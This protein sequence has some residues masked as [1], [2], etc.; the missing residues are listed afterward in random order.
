MLQGP[1][2]KNWKI[3]YYKGLGTS[4]NKE[5]KE[6]FENLQSHKI[7]FVFENEEDTKAMELSFSKK[8]V[9]ERKDWLANYNPD[10]YIDHN[11]HAITYKEF[12]NKELIHFS[13]SDNVRSIPK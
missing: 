6:Y 13:N 10:S 3:K 11:Q 7:D 8:K 1:S 9:N 2:V 5:A 4:T 12:V